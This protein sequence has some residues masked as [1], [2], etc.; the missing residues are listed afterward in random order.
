MLLLQPALVLTILASGGPAAGVSDLRLDVYGTVP[1]FSD[2]FTTPDSNDVA[3]G[4]LTGIAA[5]YGGLSVGA[6]VLGAGCNFEGDCGVALPLDWLSLQLGY[7][8]QLDAVE[9]RFGVRHGA[10]LVHYDLLLAGPGGGSFTKWV[11]IS[12]PFLAIA[13]RPPSR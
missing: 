11:A 13:S 7:G 10:I 9:L 12:S 6:D 1:L 4:L 2:D 3:L 8:V 5:R